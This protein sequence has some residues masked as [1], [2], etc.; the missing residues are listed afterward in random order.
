LR[1]KAL[2]RRTQMTRPNSVTTNY[3]HDNLSRSQSDLFGASNLPTKCVPT[4]RDKI[5]L[6]FL[7]LSLNV[8]GG[9]II[10]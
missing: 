10:Q 1:G 7:F 5:E 3:T 8:N 4:P 2:S 9:F 6:R